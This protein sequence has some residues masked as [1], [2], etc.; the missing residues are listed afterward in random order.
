MAIENSAWR[1]LSSRPRSRVSGGPV[2]SWPLPTVIRELDRR[3]TGRIDVC[4]L[5][6]SLADRVLVSVTDEHAG[7]SLR[8]EVDPAD[9]LEAFRHPYAYHTTTSTT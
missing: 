2:A 4:L 1:A 7:E 9:A 5:W 3:R 6:D 8:F